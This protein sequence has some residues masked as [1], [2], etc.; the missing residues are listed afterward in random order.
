[1]SRKR[2]IEIESEISAL[3]K[4]LKE[5]RRNFYVVCKCGG[6][7]KVKDLTVFASEWYRQGYG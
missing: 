7:I 5:V 1:M 4:E 3:Y 2:A 6:R